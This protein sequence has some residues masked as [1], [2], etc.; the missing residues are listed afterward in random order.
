MGIFEGGSWTSGDNQIRILLAS[1]GIMGGLFALLLSFKTFSYLATVWPLFALIIAT[2]F[3]KAWHLPKQ[4]RW[5]QPLLVGLLLL[6]VVEGLLT[7]WRITTLAAQTTT[8]QAYS[9]TIRQALPAERRVMGLQHYWLGLFQ[10]TADYRSILVPIFWTDAKYV[11]K[12]V[13]FPQ[14]AEAIPPDTIL[15]DQIMLDF[16]AERAGNPDQFHPLRQ[17]IRDYLSSRR[18]TLIGVVDDPTYGRMEIYALE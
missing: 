4:A 2:G 12:P 18:A 15:L 3:L 17:Q 10:T 14:A 6:G 1:V 16:L 9:E 7:R 11:S 5:W 13:P 8:Y